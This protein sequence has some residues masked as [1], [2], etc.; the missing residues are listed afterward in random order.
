MSRCD[1][2]IV[3][4]DKWVGMYR[5]GYLVHEGPD[6]SYSWMC[7]DTLGDFVDSW[8]VEY[9]DFPGKFPASLGEICFTHNTVTKKP[10]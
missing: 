7:D 2:R 8:F 1:I 4:G 9:T 10:D 3:Q 5:N 6:F